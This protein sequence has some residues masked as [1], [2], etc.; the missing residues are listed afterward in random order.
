MCRRSGRATLGGFWPA[1]TDAAAHLVR[2]ARPP[3]RLTPRGSA[4]DH[5]RFTHLWPSSVQEPERHVPPRHARRRRVCRG[6]LHGQHGRARPAATS[7]AAAP[8]HPAV[9]AGARA[10]C[11]RR[12]CGYV[13]ELV[14]ACRRT[15]GRKTG[16]KKARLPPSPPPPPRLRPGIDAHARSHVALCG[17]R[18]VMSLPRLGR[19]HR[20]HGN[21]DVGTTSGRGV[22]RTV[23]RGRTGGARRGGR[24]RRDGVASSWLAHDG[25]AIKRQRPCG[26]CGGQASRCRPGALGDVG[27]HGVDCVAH[28]RPRPRALA[29]HACGSTP[30]KS[31]NAGAVSCRRKSRGSCARPRP[32]TSRQR[33]ALVARACARKWAGVARA[34]L[35]AHLWRHRP[36][37]H[38]LPPWSAWLDS[39]RWWAQA[40]GIRSEATGRARPPSAPARRGG[41]AAARCCGSQG[42][43]AAH[44]KAPTWPAQSL[45]CGP[46][47]VRGSRDW[48]G[49]DSRT[50]AGGGA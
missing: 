6:A 8:T 41:R 25:D 11:G 36:S 38:P 22:Q 18:H 31:L 17:G 35:N 27:R 43:F 21:S 37:R 5:T 24:G 2:D 34:G 3:W 7:S 29:G 49:G 32:S 14:G 50:A 16:R 44:A 30:A 40:P 45:T 10:G 39:G 12:Y 26:L 9:Q 42:V 23:V 46:V 47:M 15:T 1:P 20:S 4:A 48:G 13:R 28:P 19:S 33:L